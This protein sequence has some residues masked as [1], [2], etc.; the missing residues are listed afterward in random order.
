VGWFLDALSLHG[1]RVQVL[2]PVNTLVSATYISLLFG[3]ALPR[4][5]G[6]LPAI[7]LRGNFDHANQMTIERLHCARL[8]KRKCILSMR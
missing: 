2:P 6:W 5:M 4:D 8:T 7:D 1:V 3:K